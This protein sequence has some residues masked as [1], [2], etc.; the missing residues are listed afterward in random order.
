MCGTY[1]IKIVKDLLN[2]IKM[3]N[4]ALFSFMTKTIVFTLPFYFCLLLAV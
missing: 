2:K 4:S 1:G 3:G